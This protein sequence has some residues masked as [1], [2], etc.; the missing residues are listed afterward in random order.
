MTTTAA[1]A[2]ADRNRAWT[3]LHTDAAYM[4][5]VRSRSEMKKEFDTFMEQTKLA[6]K[7]ATRVTIARTEEARNL[8][9]SEK[10]AAQAAASAHDKHRE[11]SVCRRWVETPPLAPVVGYVCPDPL[12]MRHVKREKTLRALYG[13]APT[14]A[15]AHREYLERD[16]D[17]DDDDAAWSGRPA[18]H[19][20]YEE[21]YDY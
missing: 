5:R 4:Q 16:Y 2:A 13:S 8:A 9:L 10:A 18:E 6:W 1:A 19:D 3:D 15:D 20:D 17:D 12:C 7:A 21:D 11:C 14:F